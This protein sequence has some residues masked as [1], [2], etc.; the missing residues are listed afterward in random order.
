MQI[1]SETQC[2]ESQKFYYQ[3][4]EYAFLIQNIYFYQNAPH[5]KR[6]T[7]PQSLIKIYRTEDGPSEKLDFSRPY[8]SILFTNSEYA[9]LFEMP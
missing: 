4:A 1:K 8:C 2:H 6:A 3:V 9:T 7:A 5:I